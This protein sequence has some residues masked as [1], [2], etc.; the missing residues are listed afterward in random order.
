MP[1]DAQR[2]LV[3]GVGASSG[4]DPAGL[5]DLL[6]RA[7]VDADLAADAIAWVATVDAKRDEAAIVALADR[8]DA[9]LRTFPAPELAAQVVPT[10][11]DVVAAAVG[12]P[13]VAEAA[14]LLA[15]GPGAELLVTK[16]RSNDATL[17]I[18]RRGEDLPPKAMADG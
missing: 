1:L 6:D 7:L 15:A 17:A 9:E 13:S 5:A 14:A 2:P 4:A 11:S 10:P 8:L 18:A 16:Q 12:T 3:V